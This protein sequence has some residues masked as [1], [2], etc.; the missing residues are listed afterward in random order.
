MTPNETGRYTFLIILIILEAKRVIFSVIY[1]FCVIFIYFKN[2]LF[3]I[4][5]IFVSIFIYKYQTFY[6]QISYLDYLVFLIL[7]L[8]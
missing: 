3:F 4:N 8:F 7:E 5:Y 6:E 1:T 2:I